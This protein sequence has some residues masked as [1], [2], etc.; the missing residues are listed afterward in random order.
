MNFAA[1]RQQVTHGDAPDIPTVFIVEPDPSIRAALEDAVRLAGWLPIGAGCAEEFL[2]R[3]RVIAPGC[4]LVEQDLPGMS[5]LELQASVAARQELPVI[6]LSARADIRATVASMKAGA[7]EFLTKPLQED[8]LL[9]S[10][11]SAIEHSLAKVDHAARIHR[12]H[13]RYEELSRR[14]REVL[15]LIAAGRLN[16]QVGFDLGISEIT[17]K[18][19]RGSMM[20]KMR[21]GSLAELVGMVA[22][23][24]GE[25]GCRSEWLS[26]CVNPLSQARA[27]CA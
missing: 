3:P 5:G 20:R 24:P 4:L 19:H 15:R 23:L 17:V 11:R 1:L 25:A 18:A 10:I 26:M 8:V 7:F 6:V 12:L 9:H 14:E 22:D 13:Q 2:G 21:A 27:A 16:K